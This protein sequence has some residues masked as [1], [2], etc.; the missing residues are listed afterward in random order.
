MAETYIIA[1]SINRMNGQEVERFIPIVRV[2]VTIPV[3]ASGLDG[4]R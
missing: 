1:T 4:T 2:S 3:V